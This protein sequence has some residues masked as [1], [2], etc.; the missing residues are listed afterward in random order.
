MQD[1]ERRMLA[2]VERRLET[3]PPNCRKA[4]ILVRFEEMSLEQAAAAMDISR[5]K[6]RRFVQRAFAECQRELAMARLED[7]GEVAAGVVLEREMIENT[8][9]HGG[10]GTRTYLPGPIRPTPL[11]RVEVNDERWSIWLDADT[12]ML[13]LIA[14]MQGL[15]LCGEEVEAAHVGEGVFCLRPLLPH[16]PP[17][18]AVMLISCQGLGAQ[19]KEL[20]ALRLK[21]AH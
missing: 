2:R 4:F 10:D 21:G 19:L 11:A 8:S 20:P 9:M 5:R 18:S 16:T 7:G 13:E 1:H 14:L 6:L 3:L 15:R 12:T 17:P